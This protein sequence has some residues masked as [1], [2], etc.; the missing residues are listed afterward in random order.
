MPST[1]ADVLFERAAPVLTLV[2]DT[3][4]GARH[5]QLRKPDGEDAEYLLKAGHVGWI[6]ELKS[7]NAEP[8]IDGADR[9]TLVVSADQAA[10]PATTDR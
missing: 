3:A 9:Q 2:I 5:Y 1:D 10:A 4:A 8:L 7:W 6:A